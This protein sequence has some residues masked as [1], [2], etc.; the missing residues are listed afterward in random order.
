M[1]S[2]LCILVASVYCDQAHRR[3]QQV[4]D[5]FVSYGYVM[6]QRILVVQPFKFVVQELVVAWRSAQQLEPGPAD[7]HQREAGEQEW[8][9]Q[10]Y[11]NWRQTCEDRQYGNNKDNS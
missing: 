6:V 5:Y 4:L 9:S 8:V 2:M 1:V 7:G 10:Q 11:H 3:D